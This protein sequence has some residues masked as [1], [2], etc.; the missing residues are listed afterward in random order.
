MTRTLLEL[1]EQ[2]RQD[3]LVQIRALQRP[4]AE[5]S[6]PR[7]LTHWQAVLTEVNK[8]LAVEP[9]RSEHATEQA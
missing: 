9:E 3:C 6:A 4:G 1:A 2:Y 8:T 5:N 7:T